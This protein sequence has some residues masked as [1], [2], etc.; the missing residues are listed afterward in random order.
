MKQKFK[1]GI[2]ALFAFAIAIGLL[3]GIRMTAVAWDN[4]PYP[5]LVNNG[6]KVQFNGMDWYVIEDNSTAEN[7]GTVTLFATRVIDQCSFNDSTNDGNKY[8]TSKVKRYLDELTNAG[9]SFAGVASGIATIP[10]LTTKGF[11]SDE[12]YDTAENVKLYLL[13]IE[14]AKSLQNWQLETEGTIEEKMNYWWLRSPGNTNAEAAFV[15]SVTR[16]IIEGTAYN[17]GNNSYSV[18]PA[19]RIDLSS[20]VFSSINLSGGVNATV[21][22]GATSQKYFDVGSTHSPMTTVTYTAIDGCK[23]PES[24]DYYTTTNG[25]TVT[26]ISDT[27]VTVSGTPNG[28]VN[29]TIPDARGPWTIDATD[30]FVTYGDI[31]IGVNAAIRKTFGGMFAVPQISYAVKAGSE[32]YIDV[33]AY[34]GTLKIKKVP[35]DGKAYVIVT[36]PGDEYYEEAT[37]EVTITINKAP[38]TITAR[39]QEYTYSGYQQG[40]GDP[41]YTDADVISQKVDVQGLKYND[42]LGNIIMSGTKTAVGEYEN[43]VQ[44]TGAGITNGANESANDNYN[45]T[46]VPGKLTIKKKDVSVTGLTAQ[47]RSYDPHNLDVAISGGTI[48]G[49][50]SGDDV[51]ID[52][53]DAKGT[54]TDANAG[55]NKPV[56]ITG[57]K[58]K[59]QDA[60]N[61][62]LASQPT[63][64]TVNI[65][66]LSSL[67]TVIDSS[68]VMVGGHTVDLSKNVTLNNATGA[69]T[70]TI[71]GEA[72]GCSL[73]GSV[74]TSGNITGEVRIKVSV[75]ADNNHFA[76]EGK[77]ISVSLTD[78]YTQDVSFSETSVSKKWGDNDFTNIAVT[79]GSGSISYTVTSGADVASVDS[80]TG[81]VHILKAGNAVIEAVA[82]ETGDYYHGFATYTLTVDKGDVEIAA[83]TAK[84]GLVYNG[85]PQELV[86]PG[87][88][89]GGTMYYAVSEKNDAPDAL[90]YTTSIPTGTGVG[91]YHVWYR[92]EGDEN[93]NDSEAAC[94][95]VII[96]EPDKIPVSYKIVFKV[97]NGAWNDGTTTDKTVTLTGYEGDE[98]KLDAAQIPAVGGKPG[99]NYGAGSWDVV[100]S[101]DMAITADKTFT[102]TYAAVE[103]VNAQPEQ[104]VTVGYNAGFKITQKKGKIKISW[105][106]VEGIAKCEVYITYCGKDFS[107]KPTK[108]VHSNFVTIKKINGNKIDFTKNIKIYVKGYD[109]RGGLVGKTVAVH[110]AGK[111]SKQYKNPKEV[112]LSTKSII[113]NK[114]MSTRIR[115]SVKMEK[116]KKKAVPDNHVAKLRF[117][118]SN[119]N[120]ATVDKNGKVT[121]VNPG[122]CVI[123]VYAKNGLKKEVT[124]TVN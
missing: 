117:R 91:T 16:L 6:A 36:V 84:T 76:L 18:R 56:A 2:N 74:L 21:S 26:R 19:L 25:I 105:D 94:I 41:V 32:D 60:G 62:V 118:T 20:A 67:A 53:T 35:A 73:N 123:Y 8:S 89:T 124:V 79:T 49:L 92:A 34:T 104:P 27:V 98:L 101:A 9:G 108:V 75:A 47:D 88:V 116:G 61:Y 42:K 46:F 112:K 64:V 122:T 106:K 24:S 70:Y 45:I 14:E 90:A 82:S 30:K 55:V 33:D 54:I 7:A 72:Y 66:K 5:E 78:K 22:G 121:G 95:T 110:L 29:V 86:D 109:N 23:F 63:G 115:A 43:E 3:Q 38:L 39:D 37:K 51:D 10:S 96:S 81:E 114:G 87:T 83:P 11:L 48:T 59:G 15:W 1:V 13:S 85:Q 58:L 103:A 57:V 119:N 50:I 12:T 69:V 93:H 97:I 111:D 102:Y 68:S 100:P 31:Y 17:V 71:D 107:E 80:A 28:V 77:T 52:I 65:N 120:V 99:N 113:L 4:N 44:V 40:E